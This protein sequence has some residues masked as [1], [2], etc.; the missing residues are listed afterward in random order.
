MLD[1]PHVGVLEGRG[2][3]AHAEDVIGWIG[4]LAATLHIAPL[5]SYGCRRADFPRIVEMAKVASSMQ[6]NPI[7]LTSTELND[8]L[9]GAL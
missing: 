7:E 5:A 2:E 6:G 3:D 4:D 8:I 9:D 1:E